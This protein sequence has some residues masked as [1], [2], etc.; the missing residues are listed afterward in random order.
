MGVLEASVLAVLMRLPVCYADRED[1]RKPG[2]LATVARAVT[3]VAND[4]KRPVDKAA[5]L[6]STAYN[7]T[8]LCLRVHSGEHRGKGRGLYQLEGQSRRYQG[9]FVGL[10][11]DSTLNATRVA[12][13]VLDRSFQCGLRPRDV[14]TAYG[15]RPCG[16]EWKTLTERV[17]TYQWVSWSLRD[18]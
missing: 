14:F 17:R 4:S 7:E 8:R 12:S 5:K 18:G 15:A 9:P 13:A 6:I 3:V 2:Q 16:S 10:D 1:D 11:Y